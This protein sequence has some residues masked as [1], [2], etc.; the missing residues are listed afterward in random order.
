MSLQ[1]FEK[2]LR[3]DPEDQGTDSL[4]PNTA[5]AGSVSTVH[6]QYNQ[7]LKLITMAIDMAMP[8]RSSFRG[9]TQI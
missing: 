3:M 9:I 2:Y 8:L 4:D 7:L 5:K 6:G 1:F